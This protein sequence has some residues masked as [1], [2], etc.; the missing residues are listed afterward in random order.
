MTWNVT[1]F[2]A[3]SKVNIKYDLH[4]LVHVLE[5]G[6]FRQFVVSF[7]KFQKYI[8]FYREPAL[9]LDKKFPEPEPPQN[10]PAPKP[11][12]KRYKD[13]LVPYQC[14]QVENMQL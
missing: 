2:D 4:V 10:R 1:S 7:K 5:R 3:F 14:C 9:A 6:Y 12:K 13:T 8:F 11:C